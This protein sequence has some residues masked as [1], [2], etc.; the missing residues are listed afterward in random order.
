MIAKHKR[1]WKKLQ[2]LIER[3]CQEKCLDQCLDLLL[4]MDEKDNLIKRYLIIE[5]I[6]D[7]SMPQRQLAEELKISI[8]KLTR[9]SNELKKIKPTLRSFLK[10]N[11][12]MK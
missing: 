12:E 6:L 2:M 10:R 1:I 7:G 4:T 8:S 5:G 3:S 11:M 9:G